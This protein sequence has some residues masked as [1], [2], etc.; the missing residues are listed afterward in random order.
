MT[1]HNERGDLKLPDPALVTRTMAEV[2]ERGQRI[3]G[4]FLKRQSESSGNPDPVEHRRR[5]HGDDHPADEQPGQ[6]VQ[7]QIGF[8]QDY[9]TLWTN[10]ARRI[11]G[12][13]VG[14]VIDEPKG[15]RRFKDDAWRENEVFDFIRQS[16]LLSARFFTSTVNSAEGL[17]P[18][19]AQKVDFYTR[20]FVDAM[21]PANFALTNPRCC[22][23]PP[24][25]AA[26]TCSR[27]CPTCCPTWSAARASCAS[28]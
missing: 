21:S 7:A 25:R 18:K 12:E 17:D 9:L 11:M 22:A 28:A 3:V 26:P 13:Q 27:A 8:W 2:A 10:T 19:T 23:A 5:L 4:D 6:L 1:Q 16:Y 24:R 14:S 20:Q 15:D